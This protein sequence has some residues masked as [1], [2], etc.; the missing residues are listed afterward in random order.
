MGCCGGRKITG[1]SGR[2]MATSSPG[3]QA[4]PPDGGRELLRRP[5][6]VP[7]ADGESL[8][9]SAASDAEPVAA[10][11]PDTGRALLGRGRA[12]ADLERQVREGAGKNTA[13]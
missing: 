3:R 5:P 1:D 9:R 7:L 8:R 10:P 12:R 13:L 4:V 11:R 2:A 6:V